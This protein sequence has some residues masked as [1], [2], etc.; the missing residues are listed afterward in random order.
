[1]RTACE[2]ETEERLLNAFRAAADRPWYCALL[3]E[4]GVSAEHVVDLDSF[5]SRCP[6]LSKGNTFDRFP[7]Q[8]LLG[9]TSIAD[10]ATVLTS[11]GHGGRFSF[12]LSTRSQAVAGAAFMDDVLDAAFQV[13]SQTTLAIYV[14]GERM[15]EDA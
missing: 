2:N 3:D 14:P 7:L 8:Q 9:T 10:L 5:S 6:A 13:K 4:H 15:S 11:S 1:M 12:G